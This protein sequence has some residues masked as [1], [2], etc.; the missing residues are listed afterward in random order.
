MEP[1]MQACAPIGNQTS[2]LSLC[3]MTL[4]PLSHT[5][6]G[7]PAER[8]E[9]GAHGLQWAR[10]TN[11]AGGSRGAGGFAEGLS[12]YRG[13]EYVFLTEGEENDQNQKLVVSQTGR[14]PLESRDFIS[15]GGEQRLCPMT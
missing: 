9:P 13:P 2:D 6:Q 10:L 1:T 14:D 15:V 12:E 7:S 8:A 4:G 5:S 11:K 3:G